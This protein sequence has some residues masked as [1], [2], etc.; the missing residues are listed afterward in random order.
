M[1]RFFKTP[2]L[3][4]IWYT[5]F[6]WKVKSKQNIYITFD[7]G[8]HPEVTPW[9]LDKLRK[10]KAKATFFWIGKNVVRYPQIARKVIEEGH[11]IG[12]HTCDHLHAC[13]TKADSYIQNVSE[14]DSILLE[15]GV[16]T[17][18]FRPPY[19]RINKHQSRKIR[20]KKI[21]MWSHLSWDFDQNLEPV[22]A[23]KKLK[24]VKPGSILVFHDSLKAFANLKKLLPRLL[25]FYDEK[26]YNFEV[27]K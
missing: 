8:P 6:I 11:A 23:F 17:E 1:I 5:D 25:E 21:I 4:R 19:G 14:C 15:A 16:Q 9:V 26:N 2:W 20:N 24:D 13:K 27:L 18:L 3:I 7:D 12:N 10:V 22:R